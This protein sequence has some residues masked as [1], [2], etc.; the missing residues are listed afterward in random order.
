MSDSASASATFIAPPIIET[1]T[2]AFELTVTDDG[3]S[4]AKDIIEIVV[5]P[6]NDTPMA[7]AG[8]DQFVNELETVTLTG[9]GE[10][11]DGSVKSFTWTQIS[12]MTVALSNNSVAIVTFKAP[13]I[14]TE[15]TLEFELTVI[16]NEDAMV[17]DLVSITIQPSPNSLTV[18]DLLLSG[19]NGSASFEQINTVKLTNFGNTSQKGYAFSNFPIEIHADTSFSTSFTFASHVEDTSS[20]VLFAADGISFIMH[21]D[22]SGSNVSFIGGMG[23]TGLDN[24]MSVTFDSFSSEGTNN[25]VDDKVFLRKSNE[26]SNPI[27][28]VKTTDPVELVTRTEVPRFVWIDYEGSTNRI[29]IYLSAT[30]VKPTEALVDSTIALSLIVGSQAYVGFAAST[31][32]PS[33]H[34]STQQ[35]SDWEFIYTNETN[36]VEPTSCFL[37]A[38][39]GSHDKVEQTPL[40]YRLYQ[41]PNILSSDNYIIVEEGTNI[42]LTGGVVP[43]DTLPLSWFEVEVDTGVNETGLIWNE[44]FFFDENSCD[45]GTHYVANYISGATFLNNTP[46][47]ETKCQLPAGT[48]VTPTGTQQAGVANV[49]WY[50]VDLAEEFIGCNSSIGWVS[51]QVLYTK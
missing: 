13:N 28:E 6:I 41:E 42:E 16:D 19:V 29:Q 49:V 32:A 44:H 27:Y 40:A 1:I 18:I 33:V 36:T 5:N 12:G 9:T 8:I 43:D 26:E 31:G 35:I 34:T 2:L 11:S 45:K 24:V 23:Y 22:P 37:K 10:D 17:S 48:S 47:G 50:E 30:D 51:E 25:L 3:G 20:N 14:S 4:T 21:N 39:V 15:E 38:I 46:D 7:D